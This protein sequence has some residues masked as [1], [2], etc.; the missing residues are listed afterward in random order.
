M[1][2]LDDHRETREGQIK[3]RISGKKTKKDNEEE[4]AEKKE[5]RLR[6]RLIPI[7]LRLI[8]VLFLILLL[9]FIG[10]MIGYGVIGDGKPTDVFKKSTWTHILEIVNDGTGSK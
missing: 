7:W 3:N 10:A 9:F 8:I 4:K 6:T 2:N 1:E 5:K